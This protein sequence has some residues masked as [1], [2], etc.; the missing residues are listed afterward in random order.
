M[1]SEQH[2]R[3]A[4]EHVLGL[5]E[6]E[7]H[8]RAERLLAS[9]ATFRAAVDQWRVYF[10]EFDETV[11]PISPS[12]SLW[13]RIEVGVTAEPPAATARAPAARPAPSA[14]RNIWE[15]L[16]FWRTAGLT[17]AFAALLLAFGVSFFA[18]KASRQ[19]VMIAVLLNSANQPGAV[20]STF[21]DGRAELV[22]LGEISI[23]D[24][25]SMQVWT[26]PD[27]AGPPVSIGLV[28]AART[29]QLNLE[30]LPR[31]QSNQL[32]EISVEPLHGSP[33]GLPTGPVILKGT[34][35]T[36]L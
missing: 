4:A 36:A 21:A 13:Q 18:D 6:G 3:L 7:E 29:V 23:P 22:P 24:N 2:D 15:S 26:L 11:A 12:E 16:P 8:T 1:S 33:T 20:L 14:L 9:D 28:N 32:F 34:A 19:P 35:S 10:A 31:P 27:P 30:K 25:H 5:L 17:A